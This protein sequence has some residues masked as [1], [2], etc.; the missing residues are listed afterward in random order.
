LDLQYYVIIWGGI[1][2]D[3]ADMGISQWD[4][5]LEMEQ[6]MLAII[7]LLAAIYINTYKRCIEL[8]T[9]YLVLY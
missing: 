1:S 5:K 3:S 6:T 7:Y 2:P 8:S 4:S 9:V